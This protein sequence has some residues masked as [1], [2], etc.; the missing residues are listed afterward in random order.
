[1]ATE[2]STVELGNGALTGPVTTTSLIGAVAPIQIRDRIRELRRVPA[3]ELLPNPKNWRRHPKAQVDALRGLLTEI[4][5]ADALLVRELADGHLMLI[6]GH[7]RAETTPDAEVPVL[8][9]DVTEEEADKI[10]L[11][12]DPLAAMAESDSSQIQRLLETVRTDNEAVEDLLRRTAGERLW[13]IVHPDE[14]HEADVSFER[15]DE[16]RNKWGTEVGQLWHIELHRV[17]CGDCTDR[18]V[19]K[20]LWT[21]DSPPARVICTDP[22]YGVSYGEKTISNSRRGH[23]RSRRAIENDSLPPDEL[24]KMCAASWRIA[25][26]HALAGAV[27]YVTVSSIFLK[28]F[29]QALEDAG[30]G[31]RHCLIWVKQQ[32]VLGRSDYHYQHEPILYGWLENGPHYFIDDRTQSSVFEINR[33]T[34]SP[35]HATSKPVELIARMIANSSKPGELI[36]DPFCGSG[37]T[38]IAAHQ[39]GRIGYGCEI[40]PAYLAV[41]L[42]RLSLLGLKPELEDQS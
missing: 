16:L 36:Y 29:I 21:D 15:A 12:L 32:F 33:P 40:D 8:V 6:D 18:A 28:Y 25:R 42:E 22:P 20:R 2:S 24:Q 27:I 17:I 30:F 7:L 19:V 9:L 1:V 5:Y 14:V 11:T 39:L 3:K 13:Q 23:G 37:S 38:I 41:E 10:L 35:D 4:G 31:Y 34:A 26:D